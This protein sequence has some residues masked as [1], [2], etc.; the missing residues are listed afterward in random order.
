MADTRLA[1]IAARAETV[2]QQ[3]WTD[4]QRAIAYL[5]AVISRLNGQLTQ[6][7]GEASELKKQLDSAEEHARLLDADNAW[8]RD[9]NK[10]IESGLGL[11]E[12]A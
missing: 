11:N 4:E 7:V 2:C 12:A 3:A 10:R 6:A 8:L 5:L 9:A 1:E